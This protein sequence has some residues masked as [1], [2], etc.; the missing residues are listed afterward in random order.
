MRDTTAA[1]TAVPGAHRVP[2][3]TVEQGCTREAVAA[4]KCTTEQVKGRRI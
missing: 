2:E 1:C 3:C 4:V